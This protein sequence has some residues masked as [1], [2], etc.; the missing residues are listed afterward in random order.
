[1]DSSHFYIKGRSLNGQLSFF[2]FNATNKDSD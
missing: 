1:M 2:L